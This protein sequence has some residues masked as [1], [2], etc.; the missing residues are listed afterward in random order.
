MYYLDLM[1]EPSNPVRVCESS[2]V[3]IE[4]DDCLEAGE[5]GV[6]HLNVADRV[7]QLGHHPH[8]DVV[9]DGV[10]REMENEENVVCQCTFTLFCDGGSIIH[11]IKNTKGKTRSYF[12]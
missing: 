4:E 9:N 5:L 6:V 8:A 12:V 1:S 7:D 3:R 11:I 10:L 2:G